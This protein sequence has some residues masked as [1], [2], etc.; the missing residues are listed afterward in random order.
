MQESQKAI[1]LSHRSI[2]LGKSKKRK[3]EFSEFFSKHMKTCRY[4]NR[5]INKRFVADTLGLSYEL[6]RKKVGG[7]KPLTKRDL[8]IAIGMVLK[9]DVD[10]TNMAL[11]MHSMLE[12]KTSSQECEEENL[13]L[14]DQRD[15]ILSGF[16]E[17]ELTSIE[18]VN[19]ILALHKL[20]LLDLNDTR[21]HAS[22]ENPQTRFRIAKK[23]C[24]VQ[25][26]IFYIR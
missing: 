11:R 19:N 6:F 9:M 25:P 4:N 2:Q 22:P 13:T 24:R 17:G 7:Q 21:Q 14:E 16:L 1:T 3:T 23:M 12:L 18:E 8:I 5:K 10:E 15:A 26:T 20:T